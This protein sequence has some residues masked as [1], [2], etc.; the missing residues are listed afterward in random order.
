M[1]AEFVRISSLCV[2]TMVNNIPVVVTGVPYGKCRI[3]P[4]Q[5]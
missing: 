2:S 5:G 1:T 4:Q 3:K